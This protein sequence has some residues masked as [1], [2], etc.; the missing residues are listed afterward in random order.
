MGTRFVTAR[1]LL[2]PL[3]LAGC[4]AKQRVSPRTAEGPVFGAG[5]VAAR[6]ADVDGVTTQQLAAMFDAAVTQAAPFAGKAAVCAGMQGIADREV[7]DAPAAVVA[8]LSARLGLPAVPASQCDID[9]EPAVR[10]TGA[11]AMLYT[12]RVEKRGR[13]G[14]LTFWALATFGNVGA[15]GTRYRL[16]HEHGRWSAEATGVEILS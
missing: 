9:D 6:P 16:E 13:N 14:T 12:V 1:V 5:G 7:A 8:R 11:K 3:M 2:L 15:H 4:E 10:A